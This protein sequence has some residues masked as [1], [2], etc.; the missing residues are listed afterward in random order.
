MLNLLKGICVNL[1]QSDSGMNS[2]ALTD[3]LGADLAVAF[4]A[5]TGESTDRVDA[6]L[7]G[8]TVVFIA[9]ALIHVCIGGET[10]TRRCESEVSQ[11]TLSLIGANRGDAV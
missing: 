4:R 9:L 7:A 1:A 10:G 2:A 6:L 8:L 5:L 3:T 11:T